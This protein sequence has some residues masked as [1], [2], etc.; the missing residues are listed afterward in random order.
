MSRT[1]PAPPRPLRRI[2]VAARGVTAMRVIRAVRD[3]A[4]QT[5]LDMRTIALHT[6]PD[7]DALFVREAD[8]A[9]SLGAALVAGHVD[10]ETVLHLDPER[11]ERALRDAHADAAWLDPCYATD[12]TAPAAVCRRIGVTAIAAVTP[13]PLDG[14]PAGAGSHARQPA[15]ALH[16]ATAAVAEPVSAAH[17][18]APTVAA[19]EAT[20]GVDL[21]K[22]QVQ[23]AMGVRLPHHLPAA[24]G[25]AVAVDL[26]I[27][28]SP[29]GTAT[30]ACTVATLRLPAGPGI[31]VDAG[32]E[33]GDVVPAGLDST[34]AR[35]V[36]WGHDDGEARARL[37]RA[38]AET[39]VVLCGAGT[40]RAAL[41]DAL[42]PRRPEVGGTAAAALL[43][44]AIAVD[45]SEHAVE[46]AQFLQ[47]AARGRPRVRDTAGRSVELRCAGQRYH[48]DLQRLGPAEWRVHLD[49]RSAAVAV[50]HLGGHRLRI[51]VDGRAHRVTCVA[52]GP[53]FHVE[54][55]GLPH[56]VR[57][58]EGGVVRAPAAAVV[59]AI[60]VAPGDSVAAGD[61]VAVLEAMKM[62]TPLC[63]PFAG[64]VA[65][66][67]VAANMQV[68]PGAP[69]VQLETEP[70]RDGA[71]PDGEHGD[72]PRISLDGAER[73]GTPSARCHDALELLRRV[74]LGF[75]VDA[76]AAGTALADH[77]AGCA[78]A[79]P[80]DER[81]RREEDDVLAAFADVCALSRRRN[82]GDDIGSMGQGGAQEG[83]F[84]WLRG[85][86]SSTLPPELA[87]T[88]RRA[89]AHYGITSLERTPQLE[90]CAY[91]M[92]RAHH[93]P[94]AQVPVVLSLLDHRLEQV[95]ASPQSSGDELRHLL[96]RILLATRHRHPAVAD[97]AREVRHRAFDRPLLE[98]ARSAVY[99]DAERHLAALEQAAGAHGDS[100]AARAAH[101]AALVDCPQPLHTLLTGRMAAASPAARA[102]MLEV[103]TRRYYRTGTLQAV[104][105]TTA[106]GQLVAV[107]GFHGRRGRA[108]VITTATGMPGLPRALRA[109]RHAAAGVN[110]ATVMAD[111]YVWQPAGSDDH[112]DTTI[113]RALAA[114][115]LPQRVRRVVVMVAG[116]G[117]GLGM[118]SAQHFTFRRHGAGYREDRLLRGLHP[119]M[120]ERLQ[121]W[122]LRNFRVRRLDSI[123]DVYLFHGTARSN[124]RDERLFALVEVRD[125]TAER[126]ASG[127]VVRLPQ[128]ERM[129][130]EAVAAI[131]A[132]QSHRAAG[133]RLQGSRISLHLWPPLDVAVDD[134]EAIAGRLASETADL[135]LEKIVVH[136]RMPD[137]GG[138]LRQSVLHLS[139]PL[140]TGV[141]MMRFDT[142]TRRP[143]EPLSD[144]RQK[145]VSM[146]R[147]GLVYPYEIVDMLASPTGGGAGIPAGDFTEHDLDDSGTHLVPVRRPQGGNTANLVAGVVRNFDLTHPEGMARVI[148]LGDPSR[149]LGALAEPECR[150]IVAALDLAERMDVPLEWFTLSSGARIAM[151]S[152]T[153]N[154]DWIAR[155]LRRLIEFTQGGGEVNLVVNGIN[156][157]AQPYWN[158]EATML[159]HTRGI[160]V[161]TPDGAMVLTGKQAL[162]YSGSVSAEDNFGIGGYERIMGPNGQ[163]QY[164]APDLATACQ[165]LFR[166][167]AHTYRMPGE[168]FPRRTATTDP[169][170]RDVRESPHPRIEGSDFTTV[171]DVFSDE[172]NPGRKKP[173]DI[174]AVM[175]AVVDRDHDPLERWPDMRDAQIAVVWDAH[176]GGFPVCLLGIESQPIVRTRFIPADGP[177]VWTPGTL[178][179]QASKKTARAVN[180]A[181]GNRPLVVLANLSGFDG[182]PE[183]MRRLQLEFGAEIGRAVVNFRGPIVF[184]V[185]SRYHGGAFVVF[186]A[187]LSESIEVAALEG[188]YASVIGGAP[189]AAVVFA[190]E[191][192]QRTRGAARVGAL[193]A[194]VAAADGSAKAELRRRM[195]ALLDA[196]RSEKLGEVAAE[197][198]AV[199]TVQRA[200][201]VGSVHRIIP[202]ASLRPYLVDAIRR[203]IDRELS[204]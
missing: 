127:R 167:Y 71:P 55:D 138:A 95:A 193:D 33:E 135:G 195:A 26:R 57:R 54:V 12:P 198:D 32:V 76:A 46:L 8:E 84:T 145:V 38:L 125:L 51:A 66:V 37:R 179:P 24:R 69:L 28:E 118:A 40:N 131:R 161:M 77:R 47:A 185:V 168:R 49:G 204:P 162:D 42:S 45:E 113:R 172:R 65:R 34:L 36:A 21:V 104:Q 106:G 17:G 151:D 100:G 82:D 126:D 60:R 147:R 169:V 141:V 110:A 63:A 61:V 105:A 166:H 97:L 35:V 89:V 140:G 68:D 114:A 3:I 75:D 14:S 202:A 183:S 178:F 30:P 20:T 117:R 53:R 119:M 11:F 62:E 165:V 99:E 22:R 139:N 15:T 73:D 5:G 197:F 81:L 74:M 18:R 41:L 85:M 44:A 156:V 96:D 149:S 203:G 191:V 64:R 160:L 134:I 188:T 187:A 180:A 182:S 108:Q 181:S 52:D 192:D 173:F 39:T 1:A 123:E 159:M 109:L 9:V 201:R 50:Q 67:L 58:D 128:L 80:S 129:L 177:D 112:L 190:R 43:A 200:Q 154:M 86:D 78:L 143:I 194:E 199:H 10:G 158:A 153:E 25:R 164:W 176:I 23:L 120:A 189:A 122:R 170:D 94:E 16:G 70:A 130:L 196:V 83:F 146:R 103:M 48:L 93:R 27:A 150:R 184:C 174:R 88:L 72:S 133:D 98:R 92:V 4:E 29:G 56:T 107:A 13:P 121:L 124:P 90:D 115:G 152:G 59:V 31:R 111:V 136:A 132:V 116:P 102:A 137:A 142:P 175:A 155:V 87:R 6:E 79:Q 148:L 19:V 144:Y 171:G 91:W 101:V 7:R 163:A 2:A 186:S 157:G